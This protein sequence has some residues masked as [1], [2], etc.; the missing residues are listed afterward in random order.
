[1]T[2]QKSRTFTLPQLAEAAAMTVRNVRSYQTRGLIPPPVRRGRHSIYDSR[3][4]ERLREI[5]QA[6]ESGASLNLIAGYLSDG[7]SLATGQ[8]SSGDSGNTAF[9]LAGSVSINRIGG[10]TE[11]MSPRI[12]RRQFSCSFSQTSIEE[13]RW[14]LLCTWM[15]L[16]RPA[17]LANTSATDDRSAITDS[18]RRSASAATGPSRPRRPAYARCTALLL[19]PAP[20]G[21]TVP[22]SP[23]ASP[24]RPTHTAGRWHRR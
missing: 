4:L 6:R 11:R 19:S 20:P 5:H 3:H 12:G 8:S 10:A 13:Q 16:L 9:S 23:P 17:R 21:R 18:R 7:G 24:A 1:M 15:R 14:P 22:D 2:P